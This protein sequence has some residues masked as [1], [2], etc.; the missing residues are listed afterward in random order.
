VRKRP[1]NSARCW[2]VLGLGSGF[3]LIELFVV[4]AIIA[5]LASFLLPALSKAKKKAL[6]IKCISNQRQIGI[7]LRLYTDDNTD[8]LPAYNDWAAWGGRKGTNTITSAYTPGN[9]LHGGNVDETNRVLNP[10]TRAVD[11][12]HCPADVGDPFWPQ[13]AGTCWDGWGNSYLM[14]WYANCYQVEFVGGYMDKG[15]ISQNPNK[16]SRFALRPTNKLLLGDWNWYSARDVNDPKTIWHHQAGKRVIPFL[17]SDNH[18][19]NFNFPPGYESESPLIPP[20]MDWK[21]W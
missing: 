8:F 10:Y 2:A 17:F 14:Q 19:E 3:T 4:I 1:L 12:Y 18:T 13:A 16:W 21:Y 7:A 11:I 6:L 5:I 20:D 9:T 15:V